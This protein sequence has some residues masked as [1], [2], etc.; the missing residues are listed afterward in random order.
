MP[1]ILEL[2]EVRFESDDCIYVE[3][4]LADAVVAHQATQYEPEECG[5]AL[6]RGT[7]F[8]CDEDRIPATD[9]ELIE[10]LASRVDDW[11]PMEYSDD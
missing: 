9:Q 6:C 4:V 8:F 7:L 5:P 2:R 3:A 1:E 10:L 11:S